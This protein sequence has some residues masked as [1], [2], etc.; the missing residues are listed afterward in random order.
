MKYILKVIFFS[1]A[2]A[3]F[4]SG[5]SKETVKGPKGDPGDPGGGGN[6]TIQAS[7]IFTVSTTQ[8]QKTADTSAWKF[9]INTALIT[10]DIVDKGSVKVFTQIGTSW[11]EL[12]Y[13]E[14][15]LFTQFGFDVGVANLYF[16]DIHGGLPARPVT[17][18]YRVITI[19]ALAR[20]AH[21]TSN[22]GNY[23]EVL[24]AM[25]SAS[26]QELK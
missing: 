4:I 13:T 2:A 21:P 3:F 17:R 11:W 18:A 23:Y 15:D 24:H 14:G 26:K 5:C 22:W 8:W 20:A 25:E 1:L 19:S 16:T 10:Q 12:P 6:S 7:S 9:T